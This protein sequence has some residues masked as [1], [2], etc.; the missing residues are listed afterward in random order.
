MVLK[1]SL[2]FCL[3]MMCFSVVYHF[4]FVNNEGS[5]MVRIF[6]SA[7]LGTC[8]FRAKTNYSNSDCYWMQVFSVYIFWAENA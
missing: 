5:D 6:F 2:D 3:D 7:F 8:S 1:G 4:V